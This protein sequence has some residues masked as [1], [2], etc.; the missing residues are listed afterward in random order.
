MSGDRVPFLSLSHRFKVCLLS[1]RTTYERI[2]HSFY[3]TTVGFLLIPE[4]MQTSL[5]FIPRPCQPQESCKV[6]GV[7]ATNEWKFM[8][9]TCIRCKYIKSA[10][11]RPS[12]GCQGNIVSRPQMGVQKYSYPQWT[13]S[14]RQC[15]RALRI[16]IIK[17]TP[18][19]FARAYVFLTTYFYRL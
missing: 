14:G 5:N 1:H 7:L 19:C 16:A 13:N 12:S 15:V 4:Q 3:S 9:G 18:G 17:H 6:V 10:F 11:L 2:A 8:T